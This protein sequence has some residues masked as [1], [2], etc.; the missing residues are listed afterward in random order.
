[1]DRLARRIHFHCCM[2]GD[3]LHLTSYPPNNDFNLTCPCCRRKGRYNLHVMLDDALENAIR[4][5]NYEDINA[6]LALG[7]DVDLRITERNIDLTPVSYVVST[8]PTGMH[9]IVR[10]C[11]EAKADL[12][13]T[14]VRDRTL[15]IAAILHNDMKLLHLLVDRCVS[16]LL[17]S[18]CPRHISPLHACFMND[19]RYPNL[20]MIDLLIAIGGSLQA[21]DFNGAD[22]LRYALAKGDELALSNVMRALNWHLHPPD[23]LKPRRPPAVL[24]SVCASDMRISATP[25]DLSAPPASPPPPAAQPP[26][27]P[28][29]AELPVPLVPPASP[30]RGEAEGRAGPKRASPGQAPAGDTLRRRLA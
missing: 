14:D 22:V 19:R 16:P 15:V 10:R 7:A 2:C 3:R 20:E 8:R 30:P 29:P 6:A 12:D 4:A 25:T 5:P 18:D 27:P 9:A 21:T 28:P 13:V 24:P 23:S 17:A 26:Q 1:M 11:V